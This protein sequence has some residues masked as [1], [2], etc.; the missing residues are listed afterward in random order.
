MFMYMY[1]VCIPQACTV[2]LYSNVHVCF[3]QPMITGE[4]VYDLYVYM[5]HIS[6][7]T[8]IAMHHTHVL[9]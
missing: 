2:Y 5:Y 1:I 3:K 9:I 7:L 8:L 6:W 4:I